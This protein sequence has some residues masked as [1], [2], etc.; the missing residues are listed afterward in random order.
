MSLRPRPVPSVFLLVLLASASSPVHAAARLEP[1][2]TG[3]RVRLLVYDERPVTGRLLAF[4][5]SSVDV[6][7]EPDSTP[8]TLARNT[9]AALEVERERSHAR[10][11][12]VL[13]FLAGGVLGAVLAADHDDDDGTAAVRG[14]ITGSLVGAAAGALLGGRRGSSP[15]WK[16]ASLP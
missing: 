5:A 11:G 14:F 16:E 15:H 4:D 7:V 8:R 10:R 1:A 3:D 12:G 13:G 2:A 6:A 9:I